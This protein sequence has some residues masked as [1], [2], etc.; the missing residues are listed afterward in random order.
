MHNHRTVAM[1]EPFI[2]RVRHLE[3]VAEVIKER[4]GNLTVSETISLA[5][6]IIHAVEKADDGIQSSTSGQR[7]SP[8]GRNG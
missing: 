4:F 2:G 1:S 3:A 6:K 7:P 5:G 8:G